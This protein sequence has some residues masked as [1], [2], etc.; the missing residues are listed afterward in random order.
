[1]KKL[2]ISKKVEN[3]N[4]NNAIPRVIIYYVCEAF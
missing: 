1:M 3:S 4:T 2:T